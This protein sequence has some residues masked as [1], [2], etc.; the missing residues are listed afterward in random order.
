M[1]NSPGAGVGTPRD[2][3]ALQRVTVGCIPESLGLLRS[4]PI[5]KANADLLD[6]TLS[7]FC[8]PP[9]IIATCHSVRCSARG[10]SGP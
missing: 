6:S 7:A 3:L 4:Q 9:S 5:P 10:Q 8:I 1:P 2:P